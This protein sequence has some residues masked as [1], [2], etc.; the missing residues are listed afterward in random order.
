MKTEHVEK[1]MVTIL[2]RE[3]RRD[4]GPVLS[5][6]KISWREEKVV[7]EE[8]SDFL[9]GGKDGFAAK[10]TAAST[11]RGSGCGILPGREDGGTGAYGGPEEGFAGPKWVVV[12][13]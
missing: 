9:L 3:C 7:D 10:P 12:D 8:R 5:S 1:K 11:A 2:M 13:R 6:L 4:Q